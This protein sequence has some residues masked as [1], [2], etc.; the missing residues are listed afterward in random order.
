MNNKNKILAISI[1][2][3][4][5][6]LVL[7]AIVWFLLSGQYFSSWSL[8][9]FIVLILLV[10]IAVV[11]AILMWQGKIKNEPN[12]YIIFTMG[13]IWFPLGFVF[14]MWPLSV[15]GAV[16]LV[17]GLKNKDKWKMKKWSEM[18][19]SQRKLKITLMV[20]LGIL[21]LGGLLVSLYY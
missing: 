7:G 21:V 2:I 3:G 11:F 20:V 5:L 17:I 14:E 9:S 18:E 10:L 16:F 1:I 15:M 6:L 12:Y 8:A 19:P 13:I 4:V